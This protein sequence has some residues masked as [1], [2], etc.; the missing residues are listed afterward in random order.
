MSDHVVGRTEVLLGLREELERLDYVQAMWEAGA[1]SFGRVDDWSD[2]DLQVVVDDDRVEQALDV[3]EAALGR[4]S[5]IDLRHR[6]REP[7]W[8]GHSQVFY[9]LR[10]ASPFL[11]IDL[12]VMKASAGDK[13]LEP[14]THGSPLVYFDKSNAVVFEPFDADALAEKLRERKA[15]L[16]VL[17]DLFQVLTLKE[18]NRGN[19]I[20]AFAFYQA[21]TLRPLIQLLRMIH[22]PVRH[23]FHTRYVHYALPREDVERLRKLFYVSDVE[24]LRTRREEAETWFNELQERHSAGPFAEDI[25]S[26]LGRAAA[27]RT[28]EGMNDA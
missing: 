24:E 20:E 26:A 8:H 18:I 2:I 22:D 6:L 4:I 7:T 14:E 16:A 15:E 5:P 28:K 3:I 19:D 25:E 27:D 23:N 12:V 17:F 13:F 1:V 9:R 21:Y 11:L 10:E